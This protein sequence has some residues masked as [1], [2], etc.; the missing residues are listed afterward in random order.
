MDMPRLLIVD[1]NEEFRLLLTDTLRNAYCV[2]TCRD[3]LEAL[4]MLR[5]FRPDLVVLDLML[6]GLDGITLL[7]RAQEEGI[8][9]IVLTLNAFPSEYVMGA[10]AK[11]EV[12]SSMS[13]PCDITAIADRLADLSAD[14]CPAATPAADLKTAVSSILL[15]LGFPTRLDGFR[16]LNA[17]LPLYMKDPGQSM[18]KELYVAIGQ[19]Y[20]KDAKQVE[21]SIRSAIATALQIGDQRL[22]RQYF[23][24]PDGQIPRPPNNE[25]FGRIATVMAQQG[26][27]M[28]IA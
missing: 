18:T 19:L 6:P 28:K 11:L 1:S 2:N 22:W 27:E 25:F 20:G 12:S 9:P 26:Y 5:S 8:R 3:G 7:Q 4:Q 24:T 23:G 13:K 14:I 21:R 17:G 10:L 15:A 16:F